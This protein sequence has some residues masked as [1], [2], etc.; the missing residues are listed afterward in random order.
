MR[1][2]RV[3]FDCD[4]TLSAVEGIDE[5]ARRAG[6]GDEVAEL[7]ARAM[8]GA[9]PLESIYGRRLELIRPDRAALE[10]LAARYL[11]RITPGAPETIGA[12]Q[13]EGVA[14]DLVSGGLR[15]ALLPLATALG[16]TEDRVHAVDVRLGEAGGYLDFERDYPLARS[17]GKAEVVRRVRAP[18]EPV[19]MVG[20]GITDLETMEAGADFIGFGGVVVRE[21][22][23]SAAPVYVEEP[24][25][26][27]VL[28]YLR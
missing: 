8:A 12:L 20:D 4:S 17:G 19:A 9:I 23:K 24:D 27:V 2:R 7:T 3:L 18:G 25:L 22:V 16:L 28:E 14:V 13:A 6:V 15:P 11:E 1:Y 5:L 26:R 21:A 10:W